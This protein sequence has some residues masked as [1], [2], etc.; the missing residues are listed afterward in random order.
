MRSGYSKQ[1]KLLPELAE[2]KTFLMIACAVLYRE[3]YACAAV[4]ENIIDVKIL[5]QGLHDIGEEKMSGRLQ[6][7]ISEVDTEKYD[8]I[9]LGYGLCNNGIRGLKSKLPLVIPRAHDCIALLM[10]SKDAY[11]KYFYDNPGTYYLSSG[12]CERAVDNLA[13]PEATTTQM[14]LKTYEEYVEEFGE[15]NAKFIMESLGGGLNQY[16]KMTYI[17]THVVDSATY[18]N[19]AQITAAEKGWGYEEFDGNTSI[20]LDMMNGNWKEDIFLVVNPGRTVVPS[21]DED[22]IKGV[23]K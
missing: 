4:S 19:Q 6:E 9:L 22:I 7:E 1:Q 14:G 17:D 13:N 20:L 23:E 21:H 12:W 11:R 15:D 2:Q 18:R 10:G 16:S 3:C 5:D 8:A